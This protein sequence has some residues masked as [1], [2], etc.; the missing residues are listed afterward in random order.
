[1][2]NPHSLGRKTINSATNEVGIGNGVYFDRKKDL[3]DAS[4]LAKELLC[5]NFRIKWCESVDVANLCFI[6]FYGPEIQDFVF[7]PHY[8]IRE[9]ITVLFSWFETFFSSTKTYFI[10]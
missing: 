10:H 3:G 9:S 4:G 8:L 6:N 7:I 1:M 2:K 5:Q